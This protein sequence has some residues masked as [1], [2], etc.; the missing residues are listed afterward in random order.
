V[1]FPRNSERG[2][3]SAQKVETVIVIV[4]HGCWLVVV[5]WRG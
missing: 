3:F 2:P 1:R 4:F 5:C